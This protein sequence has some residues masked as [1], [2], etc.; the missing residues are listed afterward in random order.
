MTIIIYYVVQAKL[1]GRERYEPGQE[2]CR[3]G[4]HMYGGGLAPL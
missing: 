3:V 4:V 2:A 1:S